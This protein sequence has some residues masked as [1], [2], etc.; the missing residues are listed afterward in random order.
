MPARKTCGPIH[1]S[2]EQDTRESPLSTR[3]RRRGRRLRSSL[4]QPVRGRRAGSSPTPSR[5][6]RRGRPGWRSPRAA[7]S[8]SRLTP[9]VGSSAR[10]AAGRGI[11]PAMSRAGCVRTS[12]LGP[13]IACESGDDSVEAR[14]KCR[15]V[16]H[17]SRRLLLRPLDC[18]GR[19][20]ADAVPA[21]FFRC[22]GACRRTRRVLRLLHLSP[23]RT[24]SRLTSDPCPPVPAGANDPTA[25]NGSLRPVRRLC[26]CR[27][28]C[29]H[30]R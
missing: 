11:G 7:R 25:I 13:E 19:G 15:P 18:P 28:R 1:R 26:S 3:R 17:R 23:H 14:R 22:G 24:P 30:A 21:R 8:S 5:P 9:Y 29:Q 12:A 20:S 4:R 27:S 16:R 2:G 10:A 6:Q